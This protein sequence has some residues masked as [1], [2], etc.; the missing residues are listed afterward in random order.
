VSASDPPPDPR[1][2]RFAAALTTAV[3]A[4]VLV[5]GST[6]LLAAQA[7]AFAL[8]GTAGYLTGLTAL[9]VTATALALA[10]AFLNA[11]SGF[12]PGC[13]MHALIHRFLNRNQQGATA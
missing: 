11:A 7:A 5:T 13:E 1:G 12:C 3:L 9:G 6:W 2:V 10:F 8:A 4:A